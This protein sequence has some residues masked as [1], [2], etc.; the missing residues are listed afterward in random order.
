MPTLRRAR[1]EP[2]RKAGAGAARGGYRESAV[3]CSRCACRASQ[4]GV[5]SARADVRQISMRTSDAQGKIAK[6][7]SARAS[8]AAAELNLSYTRSRRA[9]GWC[10]HAQAGR[11]WSDRANRARDYSWSVPLQDV[12]VTANFKETQ[13]RKMRAGQ[14]RTCMSTLTEKRSQV[15]LDSLP[16]RLALY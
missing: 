2:I 7:Q 8:S 4:S 6:V 14:K 12:W 1:S 5:S 9:C 3:N 11:A 13:L 16:E 15:H 10:G